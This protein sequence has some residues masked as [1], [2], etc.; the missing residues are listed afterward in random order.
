MNKRFVFAGFV[1]ILTL[2]ACADDGSVTYRVL[3]PTPRP[4]V[5]AS[6]VPTVDLDALTFEPTAVAVEPTEEPTEEPTVEATDVPAETEQ[7]PTEDEPAEAVASETV[8][9]EGSPTDTPPA[10]TDEPTEEASGPAGPTPTSNNDVLRQ[11]QT[12]PNFLIRIELTEECYLSDNE[13]PARVTV[14]NFNEAPFYLYVNGQR[15]F[16][17]NNSPLGPDFPPNEPVSTLDFVLL[18]TDDVFAWD[19]EDI[20]LELRGM[21]ANSGIDFGTTVFG[22]PAGEYWLTVGYSND[23]DGLTQQ[24][25]GT[26]LIP[27]AAWRGLAVSRE[28]R[29]TVVDDLDDCPTDEE[30][31]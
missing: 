1:L 10:E 28:V 24:R 17:I 19:V 20:G 25:D 15:L 7:M 29:F 12:D 5:N 6:P 18:D 30:E 8:V 31:E 26:Y 14:R 4:R 21:G 16:S 2:A 3:S 11:Q 9:A 22:L 23:K 27:Q 13:I